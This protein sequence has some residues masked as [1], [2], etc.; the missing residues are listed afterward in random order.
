[1]VWAGGDDPGA[2]TCPELLLSSDHHGR[3]R[4]VGVQDGTEE[5]RANGSARRSATA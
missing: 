3:E 1:M 2:Y 5:E 4:A